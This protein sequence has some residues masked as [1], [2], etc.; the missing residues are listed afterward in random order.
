MNHGRSAPLKLEIMESA[1]VYPSS[2]INRNYLIKVNGLSPSGD[3]LN[4]L[5]GVSGAIA[6][7]GEELFYKFVGRAERDMNH[8]ITHCKLRR[9]IKFS[10]Y[11]K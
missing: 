8:D 6:L 5:V 10:F 7:I 9:G 2:Y 11:R 4:V 3:K 1:S